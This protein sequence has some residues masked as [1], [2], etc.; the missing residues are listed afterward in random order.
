MNDRK[1][2]KNKNKNDDDDEDE[3]NEKLNMTSWW[4]RKNE[5]R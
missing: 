5:R 1:C 4:K 2:E 3:D